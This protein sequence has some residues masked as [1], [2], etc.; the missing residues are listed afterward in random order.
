MTLLI[1]VP[2][3][4][5]ILTSREVAGKALDSL[6]HKIIE[7]N[8]RETV[9]MLDKFF[10][11]PAQ[12]LQLLSD[13]ARLRPFGIDPGDTHALNE[14]FVPIMQRFPQISSLNMG[15]SEGH[16]YMVMMVEGGWKNRISRT[17]TWKTRTLWESWQDFTLR[18]RQWWQE[19]D[20]DPRDQP[21]FRSAVGSDGVHWT[22]PY[23]F[24][25]TGEL[26][27]TASIRVQHKEDRTQIIAFDMLLEDLS[28][29]T[30]G[31]TLEQAEEKIRTRLS[32]VYSGLN[33]P[34]GSTS[35]FFDLSLGKLR[36]IRVFVMGEV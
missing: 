7:A 35:T 8:A 32:G 26:G 22:E 30:R 28:D 15:D 5:L 20:Y 21:W 4:I 16:G 36:S 3:G 18:P 14:I 24:R 17:A 23:Q 12:S 29:F 13:W 10:E 27:I 33:P 19:D 6:S 34:V 2:A 31:L 9:R 25:T 1:L 11:P